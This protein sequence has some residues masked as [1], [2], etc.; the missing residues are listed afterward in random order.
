MIHL[1]GFSWFI[2]V[3]CANDSP[4]TGGLPSQPL[5]GPDSLFLNPILDPGPDPWVFQTQDHY[6]LAFTT[7][8]NITLY[9]TSQMSSLASALKRVA[10]TPP[11]T[12]PNS[13]NLWAPEIHRIDDKWYVY[14][15]ADDGNNHNHR[16]FVLEN[17]NEDPTSGH[18]IDRGKLELPGDRWAID[19]TIFEHWGQL[20][21]LWSGWE[22]S[23]N[24][25]Q[26]IYICKMS[27]PL[28]PTGERVLLTKPEL[29]WETNGVTPTVTEGPQVLKKDSL[30]FIV[31]SAGACWTD[32]YALGLLT[33]QEDADL[34]DQSSWEKSLEPVFAQNPGGNAFGPGHNGF[35]KSME[36]TED[37]IIYH[38]NAF[39]GQGCG[40][41]RSVRIQPFSWKDDGTPD[42]G[43]P[44][45]LSQKLTKPLGEY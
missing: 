26:D 10:W 42:F 43:K 40:N 31:Y 34:M 19:G 4:G 28:T 41:E 32:G 21:Y 38:A 33:A 2:L 22:G 30:L 16:M 3:A 1:L 15:A 36:G 29:S 35:F 12:G 25:R 14:Y 17:T 6:F 44:H 18:W 23:T 11:A 13:Q 5:E 24:T 20:Y 37:W 45:P 39:A 8:I 7:G 27:D 9:K